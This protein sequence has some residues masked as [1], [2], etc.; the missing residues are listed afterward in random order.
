MGQFEDVR[1]FLL[2]FIF[3]ECSRIYAR[4]RAKIAMKSFSSICLFMNEGWPLP[5]HE[6]VTEARLLLRLLV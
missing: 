3:L 5:G 6:G 2:V 1:Y 4:I